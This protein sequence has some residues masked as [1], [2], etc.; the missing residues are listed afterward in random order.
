MTTQ[1]LTALDAVMAFGLVA[2]A[3]ILLNTR[4]HFQ[5]IVQ[6]MGFGLLMSIAWARLDATD[7][8]LAEAALGAGLTG[9]LLL[10]ARADLAVDRTDPEALGLR[11]PSHRVARALL[12]AAVVVPLA[13]LLAWAVVAAPESSSGLHP[14]AHLHLAQSGVDNPV[15]ATLLNYRAYD[16]LLELSVL[17]L[18]VIGVFSQ[19]LGDPV[20]ERRVPP[21]G[22]LLLA[23]VRLFVPA[24]ILVGGYVLWRG[25]HHA[26]GAFQ[27]G[28]VVAGAGV[29]LLVAHVPVSRLLAKL[30]RSTFVRLLS[31]LGVVALAG[32]G[33]V[34]LA[35]GDPF[36]YYRDEL[37]Q[38]LILGIEAASALSIAAALI[39][40]F[41]ARA[42]SPGQGGGL[43]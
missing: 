42:P 14:L 1:A 2:G 10:N 7:I 4:N 43:R 6:F 11:A 22:S 41:A 38:A 30:G 16:T 24:S 17:L 15:T 31:G 25:S 13:G 21:S 5:A 9:V 12:A 8:A 23:A 27:S 39:A 3:A 35:A 40:V 20:S 28:A 18:A 29:L 37:A 36:L 32:T 33:L 26:G 34:V 19:R